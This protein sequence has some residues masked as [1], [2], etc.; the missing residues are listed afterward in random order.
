MGLTSI[1]NRLLSTSKSAARELG[2]NGHSLTGLIGILTACDFL[3][4]IWQ[5]TTDYEAICSIGT[6]VRI[7]SRRLPTTKRLIRDARMKSYG[8]RL[9]YEFDWGVFVELDRNFEVVNI[10]ARPKYSI[11]DLEDAGE[12]TRYVRVRQ[13]TSG[14]MCIQEK[15]E[16]EF[17]LDDLQ[18]ET[19]I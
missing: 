3:D 16:S 2:V 11:M 1:Q 5:P 9:G 18:I 6:R 12:I 19:T 15:L 17:S 14:A 13:F 8:M 4:L 7:R 10:W